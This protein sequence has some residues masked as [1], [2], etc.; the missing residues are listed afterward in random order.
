MERSSR[1]ARIRARP[2][3]LPTSPSCGRC[4]LASLLH[5]ITLT[6]VEPQTHE[7]VSPSRRGSAYACPVS[8]RV[9]VEGRAPDT[10]VARATEGIPAASLWQPVRAIWGLHSRVAAFLTHRTRLSLC[11]GPARRGEEGWEGAAQ[12]SHRSNRIWLLRCDGACRRDPHTQECH[13]DAPA[14]ITESY[15]RLRRG[16]RALERPP[17]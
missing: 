5:A 4:A 3:K 11:S 7:E 17:C 8:L 13:F 2:A 6:K 16:R 14:A 12:R 1:S 9:G 15:N 10:R